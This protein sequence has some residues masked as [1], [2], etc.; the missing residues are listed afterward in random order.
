MDRRP[1]RVVVEVHIH[2]RLA[3]PSGRQPFH[4]GP[5]ALGPVPGPRL[6]CALV[7]P[8]VPPVR[9]APQ[10]SHRRLAPVRPRQRRAPVR[11]DL[12]HLVRPAGFVAHLD[13]HPQPGRPDTAE[14]SQ[15]LVQQPRVAP[16]R[17]RQLQQD[18]PERVPEPGRRTQEPAHG[19]GRVLQPPDVG[20]VAARLDRHHEIRRSPLRPRRER[21]PRRQP[22]ERVVVLH[23]GELLR[24]ELQPSALRNPRRI[25]HA[26]PVP[27]LPPRRPDQPRHSVFRPVNVGAGPCVP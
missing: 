1:A 8:Q 16:P 22:V 15:R 11:E 27:V 14:F 2:V 19:L 20:Q 23:R 13:R 21:L 17:R 6:R 4:P 7:Q 24:V 26:P 10:R 9:G 5:Q 12:P 18:R 25:Q 3:R